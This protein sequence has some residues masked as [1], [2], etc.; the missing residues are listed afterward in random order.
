MA[1]TDLII[2]TSIAVILFAVF[3]IT[4]LMEFKKMNEE[5]YRG[6]KGSVKK[7]TNS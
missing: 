1:N 3:I 5:G 2:A 4:T 6:E 7:R